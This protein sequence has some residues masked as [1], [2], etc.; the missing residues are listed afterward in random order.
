MGF[1]VRGLKKEKEKI[2][3]KIFQEDIY[4]PFPSNNLTWTYNNEN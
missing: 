1:R 4:K 3:L 2:D